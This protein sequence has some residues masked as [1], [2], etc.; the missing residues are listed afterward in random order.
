MYTEN[1][2]KRGGTALIVQQKSVVHVASNASTYASDRGA[3]TVTF[4]DI[5]EGVGWL[6]VG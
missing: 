6:V 2:T 1:D 3:P 5:H 4:P